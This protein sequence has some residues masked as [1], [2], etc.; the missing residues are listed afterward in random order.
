MPDS[1]DEW[2]V[3]LLNAKHTAAQLAQ[4]DLSTVDFQAKMRYDF[5]EV[6]AGI[7]RD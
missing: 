4:G 1:I 6:L 7:L 2:V 3:V 5:S